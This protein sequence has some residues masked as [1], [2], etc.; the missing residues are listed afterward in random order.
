MSQLLPVL[1]R[2]VWPSGHRPPHGR[3]GL[4]PPPWPG[5]TMLAHTPLL[6]AAPG[7]SLLSTIGH[8]QQQALGSLHADLLPKLQ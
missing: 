6:P 8:S 2:C 1:P 4:P 5:A 3:Q 7:P